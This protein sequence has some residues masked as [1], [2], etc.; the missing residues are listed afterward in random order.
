MKKL[1]KLIVFLCVVVLVVI[2]GC[3]SFQDAITP[4]Y[5][6]PDLIAYAGM[7]SQIPLLLPFTTLFDLEVVLLKMDFVYTME[8]AKTE[9]E[10]KYL[11]GIGAFHRAGGQ[12][13]KA[14]LFSPT[15]VISTLIP[16]LAA[17]TLGTMLLSKPKDKK[18]IKEL[19]DKIN[20]K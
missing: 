4:C 3:V 1:Q 5:I 16:S 8:I 20:N 14:K 15:G 10:Y 7:E 13:L 2:L 18:K 9:M 6:P 12:E 11:R 17:G 19:E